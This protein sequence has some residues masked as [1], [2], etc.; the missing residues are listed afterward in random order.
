MF[1]VVRG[2]N[3]EEIS[4]NRVDGGSFLEDPI[5][6]WSITTAQAGSVPGRCLVVPEVNRLSKDQSL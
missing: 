4:Y 2:P 3:D 5:D 6:C 1:T